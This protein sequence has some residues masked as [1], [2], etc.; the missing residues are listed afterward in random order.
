MF[1][2]AGIVLLKDPVIGT[3]AGD[4]SI[5][6]KHVVPTVVITVVAAGTVETEAV[7]IVDV[8][9]DVTACVCVK[10]GTTA[11]DDA[12]FVVLEGDWKD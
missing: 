8:D 9:W 5:R 1:V 10:V 7:V 12:I 6:G 2:E 4:P 3:H 11:Q